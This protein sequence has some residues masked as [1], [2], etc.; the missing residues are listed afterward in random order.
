MAT[1]HE[2]TATADRIA[3]ALE[4]RRDELVAAA[5]DAIRA[6]LP[7][8]RDAEPALAEDVV[9]HIRTH[10]DLLCA[11][12]RRGRPAEVRDFRFVARHA[13]L[14][15]RR[16]VAFHDFL[17]AFRCY[18]NV[19]WEAMTD[20]ARDIGA[21]ADE[22][23]A[24]AGSLLRYVDLAATES[25][26]A[27]LEAQQLLVADSDRIRRDLLEDLLAGR[28]PESA[29]GLAAA[30]DAGLDGP[31]GSL[32]VAALPT[33]APEDDSAL[34]RAANALATAVSARR[35]APPLTVTRH[36]EI[37][38]VRAVREGERPA[39]VGPL[40]RACA[41]PANRR[42]ALAVGVSTVQPGIAALR[43]AYREASLALGR[44]AAT[45]GV[46]SLA[47]LTPFEYLTMRDDAVA[48]RMVDPDIARFVAEDRAHG[49]ML[50]RTL[51]AYADADLN[52]KAASEALLIHVNTAHH[53]LGRIAERTGRDL[54]RLSDVIDLLIAIRI[55]DGPAA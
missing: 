13:A 49:G 40:E 8:Y 50:I 18:H 53:R 54:R 32:V 28:D 14:R 45:G 26:A 33:T 10:H 44:V 2:A 41:A 19:V 31:A 24:A 11:V 30:R 25:S 35:G 47:D 55:T 27:F 23:L 22:A 38:L 36:G 6:R 3:G 39:L 46:L 17:E 16:G 43:D 20:A 15:A 52:A 4:A 21:P 29:A 37:V 48:R 1:A 34:R 5:F 9:G 42:L 12:L 51:V 7:V